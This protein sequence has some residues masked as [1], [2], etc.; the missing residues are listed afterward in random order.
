MQ[1]I[2]KPINPQLIR[3][4]QVARTICADYRKM[5]MSNFVRS[6]GGFAA[7]GVI[8]YYHEGKKEYAKTNKDNS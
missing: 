6:T 2:S 4:G 5:T 8:T 3:G 7:T 1:K